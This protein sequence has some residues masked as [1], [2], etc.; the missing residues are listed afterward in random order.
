MS[1]M[2]IIQGAA[3]AAMPFYHPMPFRLDLH[4]HPHLHMEIPLPAKS[5]GNTQSL[6]KAKV[7]Q[8]SETEEAQPNLPPLPPYAHPFPPFAT[9]DGRP[10]MN[11]AQSIAANAH[12]LLRIQRRLQSSN[13]PSAGEGE[14]NQNGA[15]EES[16][17][18]EAPSTNG[19]STL[20]SS[21]KRDR[22]VPHPP[23]HLHPPFGLHPFPPF[24][25]FPMV[26]HPHH[27]GIPLP[28]LRPE[29]MAQL[30]PISVAQMQQI[31]DQHRNGKSSAITSSG[32]KKRNPS[33]E[34]KQRR[35]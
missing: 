19:E 29:D 23:P 33:A 30:A 22:S 1:Q 34:A 35:K 3:N 11:P 15:N 7:E 25:L 27:A 8:G 12:A 28:P 10:I 17:A 26:P 32:T 21:E 2:Q 18:S 14:E 4:G 13:R 6:K 24:P 9:Y 20:T 31:V 5:C 16:T